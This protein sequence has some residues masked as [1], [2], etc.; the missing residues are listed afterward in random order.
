MNYLKLFNES[1]EHLHSVDIND[2]RDYGVEMEDLGFTMNIYKKFYSDD[3]RVEEPTSTESIPFYRITFVDDDVVESRDKKRR[4]GSFYLN[5][6]DT[7]LSFAQFVKRL[8]RWG[9]VYWF[10][11]N[12][13]IYCELWLPKT[14]TDIGF[15]WEH[16]WWSLKDLISKIGNMTQTEGTTGGN[17]INWR[18]KVETDEPKE[19][20]EEFL[21]KYDKWIS[22]QLT[23]HKARY[24][25]LSIR[26]DRKR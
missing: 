13:R 23:T 22:Y 7:L 12:N 9:E 1:F 2:I 25:S 5:D 14:K 4:D 20:I 10:M 6:T 19:I 3:K 15:D 11:N 21:K 26:I 8:K 17:S 18:Y 16:F 24:K